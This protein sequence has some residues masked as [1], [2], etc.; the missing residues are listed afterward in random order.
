MMTKNNNI[1]KFEMI[2]NTL[3]DLVP[4]NHPVRMY[5]SAIDW[6]F[7][8]P[9]VEDLYSNVGKPSIDPIVL[10]KM[11][12]INYIDGIHSLRKTCDRCNTDIAYR[13]F[14]RINFTDKIPDH[15]TFSQNLKRKFLETNLFKNIFTEIVRQ[16][17]EAG[18]ID[19]ENI[20]GDSTHVK[21]SA[22]KKKHIDKVIKATENLY[23]EDLKKDIN[24][25]RAEHNKKE[26]KFNSDD[27]DKP[28]SGNTASCDDELIKEKD[29][30]ELID[31]EDENGNVS[32]IRYD[33]ET[34]EIKKINKKIK[35]K[36]IKEST[37]DPDSGFYHKGEHEKIFAYSASA[38]CDVNGFVLD[39]FITS[40]NIH[41]SISFKGLYENYKKNFLH[42]KTKLVCLDNGYT[43]PAVAKTIIDD[44]KQILTP[45]KRPMTKD[46]FFKK[47]EYV[48]DDYYKGYLCPNNQLLKY[49][50]TNK[51]GYREY[52]SDPKI[53]SRCPFLSKCTNSKNHVKVTTEHVWND[54]LEQA[55]ETRYTIGSK[56]IYAKRKET[57]E[58]CFA[59]GKE[60]FGLRFTRYRG[61]KRV[62]QSLLLIF[63]CMNFKK[64][65]RWKAMA[66]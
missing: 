5:D 24:K 66:A 47:Y 8:Y 52:K 32:E 13:W 19:P 12:F 38:F 59:D 16:A 51:D 63:A 33:A 57:I 10:F 26:I 6:K 64:L 50:T 56:E 37:V 20:F 27:N 25:D 4:L 65:A 34:G 39:T 61:L 1:G 15:S 49:S 42:D 9:L 46:G 41:D 21:A 22:N 17:Y 18:F 30:D 14:L 53:C 3:E 35:F 48:Y 58:R 23:Y 62:T 45:Y 55:E 31:V 7:I 2:F 11:V 40:G 54:Y 60:N 29:E 28:N 36:H 43:S 44:G